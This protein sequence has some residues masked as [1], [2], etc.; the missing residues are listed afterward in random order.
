MRE[1]ASAH[2]L[3]VRHR[4]RYH[5]AEHYLYSQQSDPLQ[6]TPEQHQRLQ[7]FTGYLTAAERRFRSALSQLETM[8]NQRLREGLALQRI[9]QKAAELALQRERLAQKS[10]ASPQTKSESSPA[11]K[12]KQPEPP[13][14]PAGVLFQGQNNKK[15]QKK[16]YTLEQWVEVRIR[17]GQ[18][19]TRLHP[20]NEQL[21]EDG[22]KMWPPP[23]LVYRRFHFPDGIPPEY[24]WTAPQDDTARLETGGAGIQRM[25]PDTWLEV[26]EREKLRE[27]GHLGPT[28][29]GNL[30]RPKERGGCD[31]PVCSRNRPVERAA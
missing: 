25:T 29:I 3:L 2:W 4:R 19:V 26:I 27:D 10:A 17:D 21:I 8:R 15:K 1:V 24:R 11:K 28:G 23:D 5:Q 9:E 16:I 22:K 13:Q 18:T 12:T 31:C 7:T 20:S 14:T 30:P 6:W